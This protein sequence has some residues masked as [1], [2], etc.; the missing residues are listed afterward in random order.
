M[1]LVRCER[2]RKKERRVVDACGIGKLVDSRTS[3]GVFVAP[4]FTR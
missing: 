1:L 3:R 2:F 4:V